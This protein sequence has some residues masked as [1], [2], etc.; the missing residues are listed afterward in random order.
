MFPLLSLLLKDVSISKR[1][2]QILTTD[3]SIIA[4]VTKQAPLL[5]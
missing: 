5:N 3:F 1:G 4:A 2:K